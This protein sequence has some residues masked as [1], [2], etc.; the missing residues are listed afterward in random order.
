M[1]KLLLLICISLAAQ[2]GTFPLSLYYFH[3]FPVYFLLSNLIAVPLSTLILYSGFLVLIFGWVPVL[4]N[5]LGKIMQFLLWIM[6]EAMILLE[7]LPFA[8]I[9]RIPVTGLQTVLIA[10]FLV[11]VLVFLARP[12]FRTFIMAG[13]VL[14]LFS[15]SQ[16]RESY[17]KAGQKRFVIFAAS[18]QSVMGFIH[19]QHAV[20]LAD[21]GFIANR[22]ARNFILEPTFLNSRVSEVNYQNWQTEN[23]TEIPIKT[24]EG[25]NLISWRNLRILTL[26]KPL[27]HDLR[28][29]LEVDVLV[30]QKNVWI[31]PEKLKANFKPKIIVFDSSN[32]SW[33][34]RWLGKKL[35]AA[36]LLFHDVSTNGAF[37]KRL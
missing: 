18:L 17:A 7:K 13:F 3:Q 14:L 29:P 15:G 33:Y 36:G 27:K 34:V 22:A 1:K 2:I 26:S 23:A 30:L 10:V 9:N 4:G 19:D 32:E 6:N 37:E 11:L 28:N 35:D 8:L 12:K 21:S 16:I 5:W 24:A 20:I 31:T 25:E